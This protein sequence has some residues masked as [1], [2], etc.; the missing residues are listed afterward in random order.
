MRN[1]Y[2]VLY[3]IVCFSLEASEN[4]AIIFIDSSFAN[5]AKLVEQINQSLFYSPTLRESLDVTVFDTNSQPMVFNG[6]INYVHDAQGKHIAQYRP[7]SLP[8]L[9]CQSAGKVVLNL[10]L[11]EKDQICLCIKKDA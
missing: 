3:F 7:T 5:Q 8:A 10:T 4:H 11:Q 1:L 9:Y 2:F 6:E